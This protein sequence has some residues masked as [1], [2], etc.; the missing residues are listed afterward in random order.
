MKKIE[1]II[2]LKYDEEL[3]HDK[4]KDEDAKEWFFDYILKG[5]GLYLGERG[6]VDDEIGTVKVIR[7]TKE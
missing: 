3:M 5:D 6:E 1:L 7:I 4:D 2:E